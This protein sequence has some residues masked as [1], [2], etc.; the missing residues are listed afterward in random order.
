MQAF[1]NGL[2]YNS[3]MILDSAANRRF[4]NLDVNIA[5]NVVEEMAIHNSQYGNPR[6]FANKGKHQVDSI[7]F[8]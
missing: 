5:S 6:G 1:Y 4:M 7:S 3:R 2:G 8:L